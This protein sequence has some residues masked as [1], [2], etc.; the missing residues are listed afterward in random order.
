MW[1]NFF[2]ILLLFGAYVYVVSTDHD[3]VI[4][5]KIATCYHNILDYLED[6]NIEI[7][8]NKWPAKKD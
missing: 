3:K 4:P 8:V 6:L 5:E 7:H 1:K 2:I